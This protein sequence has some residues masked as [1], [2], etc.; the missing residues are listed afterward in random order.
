M[1]L[2]LN[3]DSPQFDPTK[4]HRDREREAIS[5]KNEDED[6]NFQYRGKTN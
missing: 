3:Y 2:A 6:N 4:Y 1:K 5:D